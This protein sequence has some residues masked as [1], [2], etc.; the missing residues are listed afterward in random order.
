MIEV[1]CAVICQ[2][3][4][5]LSVRRSMHKPRP[6]KWEFPGGK[7]KA[8]ESEADSLKREILEELNVDIVIG[9]KLIP[10][11]HCYPDIQ[12]RLIP[13]LAEIK[14]GN[15]RLVDHSEM[16]WLPLEKLHELDWSEADLGVLSQVKA[17][18]VSRS[19]AKGRDSEII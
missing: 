6:G 13:F 10:V 12:I 2:G 15:I 16:V 1:T 9:V 8:G 18:S 3:G 17:T 4:L 5:V 19:L 14:S 11:D 7:V